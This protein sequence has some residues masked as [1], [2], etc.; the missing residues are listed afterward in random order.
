M[1][2][3]SRKVGEAI[4]IGGGVRVT[5]TS[6]NGNKVRIGVEAPPEVRVDREEVARRVREFAEETTADEPV[7][8]GL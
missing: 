2:V 7:A 1:L 6:I 4:V 5:I 3:L 8:V